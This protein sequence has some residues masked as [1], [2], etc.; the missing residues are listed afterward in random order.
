MQITYDR[1]TALAL[2]G[3][4]TVMTGIANPLNSFLLNSSINTPLRCWHFLAQICYESGFFRRLIENLNYSHA[5]AI[6]AAWPRLASRADSLVNNPE[7]L[8]NAAYASYV[9]TAGVT[10]DPLGNGAEG[11]GNGWLYRGRGLIQITGR[12]NYT[13]YATLTGMDIFTRPDLAAAPDSAVRLAIAF[14]NSLGCNDGADA[15]DVA[16]VTRKINGPA[17]DG[18]A[19]RK[20]LRLR[21]ATIFT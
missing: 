7:A 2:E 6:A 11:N 19:D 17:M 15:D 16:W 14:W 10:H 5:S 18:L 1:L 12:W 20:T 4:R 9:D 13:H 3:D 21:A 8:A